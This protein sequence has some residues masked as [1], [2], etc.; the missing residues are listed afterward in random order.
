[1][2]CERPISNGRSYTPN[3]LA[4]IVSGP[5]SENT[6]PTVS[7]QNHGLR[8]MQNPCEKEATPKPRIVQ[9]GS[10]LR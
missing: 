2:P 5:I 10:S 8:C 3:F 7:W 4:A 1:M 9:L 6:C